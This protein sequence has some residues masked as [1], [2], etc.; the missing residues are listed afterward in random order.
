[1][2]EDSLTTNNKPAWKRPE[3]WVT[4][5]GLAAAGYVAIRGLDVI[6]PLLNR[7]LENLLYTGVLAASLGV[8]GFLFFNKDVHKLI[9]Y[10]YKMAMKKLTGLLIE[11]DPIAILE[12]YVGE[13]EAKYQKIIE[14][15][16]SLNKQ[17][18]RMETMISDKIEAHEAS[19]KMMARASKDAGMK[20]EMRLQSRKAGRLEK[21]TMTYQGLLN[22][23]K[24][25]I[26]LT[27][28]IKEASAFMIE[29][30][31]DTVAEE[32]EKRA[33]IRESYKAMAASRRILLAGK[34]QEMY[35]MA[36]ESVKDDYFQKMGEIEQ[37]M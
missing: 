31:K 14:A 32:K 12:T 9:W 23:L 2:S 25:H 17:R 20:T 29:D 26:A 8:V 11:I 36:L 22:Q 1:M 13:L 6:L 37:F 4:Y 7:V 27:Q 35:D 24:K 19:M 15:L 33:T 10:G 16:S 18:Q 30:I 3:N 21:S 5:L 34:D 28:K